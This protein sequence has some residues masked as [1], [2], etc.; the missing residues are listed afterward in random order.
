MEG[1]GPCP[2]GVPGFESPPPHH[3]LGPTVP[4]ENNA[5]ILE[6][7]L[8]LQKEGYRPSTIRGAIKNLKAI[9]RHCNLLN[10]EA[11]KAYLA[12]AGYSENN[13]DKVIGDLTRFYKALNI[14]WYRPL[15][16]RV[17][18][19]PFIPQESEIDNL[20]GGL[21]PKL[22]VFTRLVKETGARPCE[23]Y[24]LKWTD[25]DNESNTIN[26]TPEKGSRPRRPRVSN[27]A[28]AGI[29]ALRY[30]PKVCPRN[31]QYIFHVEG[32]VVE[33]QYQNF[34]R[35]F[36][37]QRMKIAERLQN[38]RIRRI[39]FKTLRHWKASTLYARTKDL[40]FVKETLGHRSISSTMKYTHLIEF[41]EDD[42]ICKVAKTVKEASELVE[43]GFDYVCDV[44]GYK[45]FRKRK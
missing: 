14:K 21:G 8:W 23:M 33:D 3:S 40:L 18:K 42:Y 43:S 24:Q 45:L 26:I 31:G 39:S 36:G 4:A 32:K 9:A 2:V 12:K 16:R 22:S 30:N 11:V 44:D 41:K 1:L 25:V 37:K 35:N 28:V 34:Y 10:P 6:H 15:S 17:E 20:I 38:P 7:A 27:N 19:L 29:M 5:R 13:R